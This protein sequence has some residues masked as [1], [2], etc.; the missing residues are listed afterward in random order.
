MN[1]ISSNAPSFICNKKL[2]DLIPIGVREW[3]NK[4]VDEFIITGKSKFVR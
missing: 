4:L 1:K 2:L 3:H